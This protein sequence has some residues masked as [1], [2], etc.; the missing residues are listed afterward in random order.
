M[1]EV[2]SVAARALRSMQQPWRIEGKGEG[3][4]EVG[5]LP[6]VIQVS[7]GT[8]PQ[9]MLLLLL[10]LLRLRFKTTHTSVRSG[11]QAQRNFNLY[12]RIDGGSL[13]LDRSTPWYC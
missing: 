12:T 3:T 6:G 2:P 13:H 11:C 1:H 8:K 5:R 7:C 9:C 4:L 10:V